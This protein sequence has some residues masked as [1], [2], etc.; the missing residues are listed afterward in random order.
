MHSKLSVSGKSAIRVFGL[1]VYN[2]FFCSLLFGG[3][4]PIWRVKEL[5]V[6]VAV[7]EVRCE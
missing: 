6:M 3:E 7:V 4:E 5:V 1:G 2:H